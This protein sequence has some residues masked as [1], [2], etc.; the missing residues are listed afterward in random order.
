MA[1]GDDGDDEVPTHPAATADD[2]HKWRSI[3]RWAQH[4]SAEAAESGESGDG[5]DG[6]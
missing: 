4:D 6:G 2:V 3:E 1:A 5:G